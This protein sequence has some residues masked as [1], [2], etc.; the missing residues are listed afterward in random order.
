MFNRA[1]VLYKCASLLKNSNH[2]ANT[3]VYFQFLPLRH[4]SSTP[5]NTVLMFVPQQEAW[6]VERMGKFDRILEPGLNILVPIID[7]VKYVQSLKEIAIDVPKQS[8]I[9]SDNVTLSIDGVL[10]LRIIDPYLAS[11][12]VEDPEFAITQLAQT[13]MRSELGKISLDKVFR[14]RE[15]LNVSIVEAINKASEAWGITCLRYEIRDIKLPGRV[16]EAMQMQVEAERKKRAAILESEG[17]REA[18]INVA[19]GKRKARILAS[20]A[21]RQEQIN[22]AAGEA[23]GIIAIAD[24]RANSLKVIAKALDEHRGQNAASLTIAEQYVQAFNKL[25]RVNNTLILPAN[26]GDISSMVAQAMSIYGKLSNSNSDHNIEALNQNINFENTSRKYSAKSSHKDDFAE[27]FS[28]DED[29][30]RHSK[31][32]NE[33]PQLQLK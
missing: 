9:T 30:A 4:R 12:G 26:A 23:A 2:V 22:K 31:T 1:R 33:K 14:E 21:E 15:N 24:A 29:L 6:I 13:T 28:D 5:I 11:Y 10:Y 16:Q 27:Y 25:A 18:D 7:K 19:E 20:E 32:E 17:V 8:A 3:N